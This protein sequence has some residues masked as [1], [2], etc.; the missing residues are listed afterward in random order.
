MRRIRLT[1]REF[2]A[3][4]AIVSLLG[5]LLVPGLRR[6]REAG[7]RATCQN[8]LKQLGLVCKMFSNE[9]KGG[10]WPPLSPVPGNWMLNMT[11]VYPE[12][13]SDLDI[14][15]C[16]DSPFNVPGTFHLGQREDRAM[17]PQCVSSLFY[18]YTGFTLVSDEEAVAFARTYYGDA[19]VVFASNELNTAAPVWAE[20]PGPSAS[21][22]RGQHAI[23]VIWDRVPL[24]EE[25]FAHR[26]KGC[27]VLHMDGHVEFVPYSYY[28]PPNYFPVT[29]ISAELFGSVLPRLPA[30]CY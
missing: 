22:A 19:S 10:T 2:A 8:N 17:A 23:P 1:R 29:R 4:V 21:T 7:H 5:L 11:A 28:N 26:P 24:Y 9:S 6:A 12:Y 30:E 16:P 25:E 14:L 3:S 20:A 18:I 15:K 13:L 27:N